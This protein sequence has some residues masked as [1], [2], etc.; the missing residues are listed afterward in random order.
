M[1]G[2]NCPS[3]QLCIPYVYQCD[4]SPDCGVRSVALDETNCP[5]Q[6]HNPIID[7]IDC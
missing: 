3:E 1:N 2:I 5:G 6:C 7:I 4:G